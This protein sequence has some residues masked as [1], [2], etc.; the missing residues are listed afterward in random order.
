MVADPHDDDDDDDVP[1]R[2]R[3]VPEVEVDVDALAADLQ[4]AASRTPAYDDIDLGGARDDELDGGDDLED[5]EA[6]FEELDELL[7]AVE[8]SEPSEPPEE[9]TQ[10]RRLYL[11]VDGRLH[12]VSTERF[13]IGRVSSQCDLTIVDA[14]ISRQHCAIERRDGLFFVVDLGST[15]G[16]IVDGMRVDDHPIADGE[17]LVLSGHRIVCSFEPPEL[18]AV[19]APQPMATPVAVRPA[20]TA[21]LSPVSPATPEAFVA[22]PTAARAPTP[23]SIPAATPMGFEQRV[24]QQLAAMAAQLAALTFA[25]QRLVEQGESLKGVEALAQVIQRRFEQSKRG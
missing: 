17:V 21:R 1:L 24:E 20:V 23:V 19:A 2:A 14:N 9:A 11:A 18:E 6:E 4:T 7:E 22:T 5:L 25:V 8:P 10:P 15:N 3:A 16:I 12:V 13:V